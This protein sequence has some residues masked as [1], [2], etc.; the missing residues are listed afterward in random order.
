MQFRLLIIVLIIGL[1]STSFNAVA[2]ISNETKFETSTSNIKNRQTST[3]FNVRVAKQKWG[4]GFKAINRTDLM[5][6]VAQGGMSGTDGE[7]YALYE[8]NGWNKSTEKQNQVISLRGHYRIIDDFTVFTKIYTQAYNGIGAKDFT[9]SY[10]GIGYLGLNNG[11]GAFIKLHGSVH[12]L[13]YDLDGTSGNQGGMVGWVA[14]YPFT[15]GE[16]KLSII[17]WNDIEFGRN[18]IYAED[19]NGNWGINGA[20]GLN[21]FIYKKISADIVLRYAYNKLGFDGYGDLVTFGVK[22]HF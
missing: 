14:R 8:W 2:E 7:I 5:K 3:Y 1:F 10:Y 19:Q 13:T 12:R 6:L 9:N 17:N 21:Y 20:I 15:I 16:H 4:A 18:D 22:F 11:K